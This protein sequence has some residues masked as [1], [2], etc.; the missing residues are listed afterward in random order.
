MHRPEHR[1]WWLVAFSR[2]V[3]QQ[4]R[5][6][7]LAEAVRNAQEIENLEQNPEEKVLILAELA[8]HLSGAERG[9]LLDQARRLVRTLAADTKLSIRLI[10]QAATLYPMP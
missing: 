1:A 10:T 9:A 7:L 2:H 8:V 3:P 5:T 6:P 4:D